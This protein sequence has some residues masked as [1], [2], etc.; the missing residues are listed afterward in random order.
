MFAYCGNNPILFFDPTGDI[1]SRYF[2]LYDQGSNILSN[3]LAKLTRIAQKATIE[4]DM[5]SVNFTAYHDTFVS[6]SRFMSP[7]VIGEILSE[8]LCDRYAE[9]YGYEFLF[10]DKCVAIEIEKHLEGYL[11][12]IGEG[13]KRNLI[14]NIGILWKGEEGAYRSLCSAEIATFQVL[15]WDQALMFNYFEGI[16]DIYQGTE[17]DPWAPRRWPAL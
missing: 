4:E 2:T 10:S 8:I 11:Y 3:L 15:R 9:I 14:T 1:P 13:G 5:L 12:M 7:G 6:A 17:K 16:R